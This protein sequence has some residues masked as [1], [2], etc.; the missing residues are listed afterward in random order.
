[1]SQ[2][3]VLEIGYDR[4]VLP[5]KAGVAGKLIELLSQAVPCTEDW[6]LNKGR[7]FRLKPH[8]AKVEIK[9]VETK[10][11]LPPTE[12]DYKDSDV[13]DIMML[14]GAVKLLKG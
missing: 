10:A 5:F 9:I 3:I 1:M 11:I 13:T 4:Y 12:E 2:A 6:T 7:T 8:R 14:P